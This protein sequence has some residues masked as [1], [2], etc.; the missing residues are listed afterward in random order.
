[1]ET[2]SLE[3]RDAVYGRFFVDSP[4]GAAPKV[5]RVVNFTKTGAVAWSLVWDDVKRHEDGGVTYSLR[6]DQPSSW[7]LSPTS[8]AYAI[9]RDALGN[10]LL[11]LGSNSKATV[12]ALSGDKPP[13]SITV[14][15]PPP[16]AAKPKAAAAVGKR[17]PKRAPSPP[18]INDFGDDDDDG[19]CA[20]ADA[21]A[22]DGQ[23]EPPAAPEPPPTK[24]PKPVAGSAKPIPHRPATDAAL[25]RHV[26]D[27]L[28]GKC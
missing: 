4:P 16:K 17:A 24:R 15:P 10:P 11:R 5:V 22:D 19:A 28:D 2:A 21:D 27:L 13:L 25:R 1:M 8:G 6:S 26:D 3:L 14:L 7:S 9:E 20:D 12:F 23:I 18:V